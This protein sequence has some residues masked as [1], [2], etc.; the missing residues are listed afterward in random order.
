M[1]D[2]SGIPEYV[3]ESFKV[4]RHV[5]PKLDCAKCEVIV[6][7]PAPSRPIERGLAGLGLLAH[8]LVLKYADHYPLYRQSEIYAAKVWIWTDPRWPTGSGLRATY[9]RH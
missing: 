5:G 3:P 6:E 2:M 9:S 8:L 4:I 1:E 7:A